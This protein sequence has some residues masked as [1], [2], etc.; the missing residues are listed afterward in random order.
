MVYAIMN[1]QPV[2]LSEKGR[3]LVS[4]LAFVTVLLAAFFAA[5]R[6]LICVWDKPGGRLLQQTITVVRESQ[7]AHLHVV[8]ML[9]F[10][11]LT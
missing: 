5:C 8:E 10:M 4:F 1:G 6:R 9:R 3:D 2:K 11:F 7:R